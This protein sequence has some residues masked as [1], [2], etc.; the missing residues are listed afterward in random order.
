MRG[1]PHE[2][3]HTLRIDGDRHDQEAEEHAERNDNLAQQAST[4]LITA[5][6]R[7]TALRTHPRSRRRNSETRQR[8]V[9]TP[10]R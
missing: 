10:S 6:I 4:I 2:G 7:R 9:T 8:T 5:G 3:T 1:Q